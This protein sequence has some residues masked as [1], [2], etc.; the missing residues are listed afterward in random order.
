MSHI[1]ARQRTVLFALTILAATAAAEPAPSFETAVCDRGLLDLRA[2]ATGRTELLDGATWTPIEDSLVAVVSEESRLE[3]I[4][5]RF[6]P[7][8]GFEHR[9][10]FDLGG[11]ALGAWTTGRVELVVPVPEP[12]AASE[13]GFVV[14]TR[15]SGTTKPIAVH[16]YIKVKKLNSGG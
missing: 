4:T 3:E 6:Q 12:G 2:A 10:R 8:P 15:P 13:D 1:P 5:L 9:V 16:G 7:E 14:E 11:D